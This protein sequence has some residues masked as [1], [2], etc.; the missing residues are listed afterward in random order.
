MYKCTKLLRY[1]PLAFL[2]FTLSMST[3]A[4]DKITVSGLFKNKAIINI[5]GKQRLLTV[6]QTSPEGIILISANIREAVIEIDGNRTTYQLGGHISSQFKSPESGTI[7]HIAPDNGG[8]Y[9]VNG[10]INGFQVKF[11]VDTGATLIA[12]NKHHAKRIGINYKFK[13]D[14]GFAQTASGIS[15]IYLVDLKTVMVGGIKL[16][17]IK[18]SV[19]DD[20]FPKI[21]LLGNSFLSRVKMNRDG[22]M[23]KLEEQ[24]N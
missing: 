2:L 6:G 23:L 17:D 5:N 9:R 11:L 24:S 8:M 4:A 14:T 19:H 13:G 12:M 10:S 21:I 3:L 16:H 18:A 20:D 22:Q 1:F 15:K 7:V